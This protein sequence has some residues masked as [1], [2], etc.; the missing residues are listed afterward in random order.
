MF[1]LLRWRE[2]A[3][4]FLLR[5]REIPMFFLLRWRETAKFLPLQ[6]GGQEGDGVSMHEMATKIVLH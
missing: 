5:W 4:F 6:G 1:F 2:T 3:M